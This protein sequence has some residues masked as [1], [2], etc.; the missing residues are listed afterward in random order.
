MVVQYPSEVTMA[1]NKVGVMI[2]PHIISASPQSH[3]VICDLLCCVLIYK[4]NGEA[5][6]ML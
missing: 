5:N 4:I 3:D 2:Y 6:R 1:L